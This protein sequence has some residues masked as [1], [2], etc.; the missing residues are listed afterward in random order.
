MLGLLPI[1][2]CGLLK[3]FLEALVDRLLGDALRS[4]GLLF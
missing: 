3:N 1:I 2:L 4:L